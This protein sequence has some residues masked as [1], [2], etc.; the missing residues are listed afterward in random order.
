MQKIKCV[1]SYD[2]AHF[3]GFQIQP[4]KRTVQGELEKALRTIHKGE[5]IRIHPSGRTDTGVHAK[6][7]TIHF[8]TP[9]TLVEENWM[10][11]LNTL[12]PDDIYIAGVQQVSSSFH[13]R[14]D[15][16]EKEYRYVVHHARIPDV[17]RRRYAYQFRYDLDMQAMQE[18]CRYLHGTHNF[19]TFSSAKASVKGS[20]V[21]TLYQAAC[22]KEGNDITFTFRGDGFL[23]NMVRIIVGVL[24]DIGQGKRIPAD[25]PRLLEAEDRR[26][27]GATVP[28]EGLYLWDVKYE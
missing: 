11:A 6:G 16:V 24:L 2:G 26:L 15:A 27:A 22:T 10:R 25:I 3:S 1:L 4:G 8:E 5:W 9:Y 14:Y 28:P 13:A 20:K 23:Y 21:R 7:Q 19:T 18:A 17:F 12:V